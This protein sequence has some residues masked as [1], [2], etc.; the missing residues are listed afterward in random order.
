[1]SLMAMRAACRVS[2]RAVAAST[3]THTNF[4]ISAVRAVNFGPHSP[5][6]SPPQVINPSTPQ[7]RCPLRP[8]QISA[9]KIHHQADR[10][11]P[12]TGPVVIPCARLPPPL[13]H[14]WWRRGHLHLPSPPRGVSADPARSGPRSRP[15]GRGGGSGRSAAGYPHWPQCPPCAYPICHGQ[16]N[17]TSPVPPPPRPHRGHPDR[18]QGPQ[19]PHRRVGQSGSL[20]ARRRRLSRPFPRPPARRVRPA[21][22]A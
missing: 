7:H 12:R 9:I 19:P 11:G 6:A 1:V 4:R 21:D 15:V 14:H 2:A 13:R 18:G 10:R 22:R 3:V 17:P 5:P 16:Y 8:G 20:L